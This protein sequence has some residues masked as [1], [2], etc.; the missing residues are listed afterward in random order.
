LN[1]SL[2]SLLSCRIGPHLLLSL[3]CGKGLLL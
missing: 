2:L 3:P 1:G